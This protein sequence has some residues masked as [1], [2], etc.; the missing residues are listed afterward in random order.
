ML[1]VLKYFFCT[2][3]V[4]FFFILC[5]V[6]YFWITDPFNVRPVIMEVISQGGLQNVGDVFQD[7]GVTLDQNPALT[8]TQEAA[9]RT[10]GIDPATVPSTITPEMKECFADILGL[11]RVNEIINGAQP[12]AVEVIKTK[13]CYQ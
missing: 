5:G 13:E 11:A 10:I 12:T 9:L 6:A 2:L 3:G 1:K 4:I 7:A 8:T